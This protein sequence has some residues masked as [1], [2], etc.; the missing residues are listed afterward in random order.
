MND[1]I[2][3]AMRRGLSA[4][5]F[6][7]L[8][9]GS[10]DVDV[11]VHGFDAHDGHNAVAQCRGHQIGGRKRL[12]LSPVITGRIGYQ[13]HT[14]LKVCV[15]GAQIANIGCLNCYHCSQVL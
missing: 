7:Y 10:S 12:A 8:N 4:I 14:R 9:P 2:T 11:V 1:T 15:F 3:S 13:A 5:I 6:G